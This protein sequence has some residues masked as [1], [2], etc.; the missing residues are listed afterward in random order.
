MRY[1]IIA[2]WGRIVMEGVCHA[3]CH[4]HDTVIVMLEGLAPYGDT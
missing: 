2:P 4:A 3:I 1:T